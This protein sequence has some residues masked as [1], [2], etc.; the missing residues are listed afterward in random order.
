METE[1]RQVAAG[2]AFDEFF[3][4][5]FARLIAYLGKLGFR[6]EDAEDA[7]E[8]AMTILY[9]RWSQVEHP[10][11]WVRSAARRCASRFARREQER[12]AREALG[13]TLGHD[14]AHHVEEV[15]WLT[16]ELARLPTRE[17]DVVALRVEGFSA[18][19]IATILAVRPATVRSHLRNARK[20]LLTC[21]G[22]MR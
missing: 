12:G 2:D 3:R 6:R 10:G 5:D 7:A 19:E 17:R 21:T 13:G 4:A 8:E 22:A 9:T 18:A 20:R 14:G 1:S 11:A 16:D 15:L